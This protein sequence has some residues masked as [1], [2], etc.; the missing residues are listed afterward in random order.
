MSKARVM[1]QAFERTLFDCFAEIAAKY[2][3]K[4]ALVFNDEHI[5][6]ALLL[7]R[8]NIKA[9]ALQA[10]WG[11]ASGARVHYVGLND[12]EQ[13]VTLLACA[14][15][16][17][18]FLPINYRLAD[19]EIAQIKNDA[20]SK[21]DPSVA[22]RHLPYSIG[23]THTKQNAEDAD[24][25]LPL[26]SRGN[27]HAS[28]QRGLSPHEQACLLVYT[29]GTT[30]EHKG[31]LHT[32]AALLAN[33]R[34][35]WAAH[36]MTAN[37]VVLS[38][39]PLFH[40]GGLCIQTLPAL[41]LGATVLLHERFDAGAWLDAVQT[42]RPTLSL[43]V[44]ATMKAIQSESSWSST[45]LS[46]L[47]GVMAG[48][49]TIPR[50]LIDAFHARG[51]PVGQIYGTTETGPVSAVLPFAKAISH[52][53]CAGWPHTNCTI[54]LHNKNE[55]G[56]GEVCIQANNL[57]MGYWNANNGGQIGLD[58]NNF[59]NTGDL[60]RFHSDG[61][62]EIVGRS[63]DM[64]ISGGE[65]I[66]PAEIENALLAHPAIDE[67]AVIGVLDNQWGEIPVAY[68]VLKNPPSDGL[69]AT[70][71]MALR[72]FLIERIAKFKLPKRF[73]FMKTLPKS[74]LGKVLKMALKIDGK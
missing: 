12:P 43:V 36:N 55:H 2:S 46:S 64:L 68:V 60:G 29:S 25:W 61:C 65:N 48:S 14:K 4:T 16:G 38:T 3:S 28:G 17:A 1:S 58:S 20:G 57:M 41:L 45:D 24:V 66:Y 42:H 26:R 6:Y 74:A 9:D 34:A 32:Q 33:A 62:L 63:K 10:T 35:A 56:I 70:L 22:A 7:E 71:D 69:Q 50:H 31:A 21:I 39:L 53:G 73:V 49:S 27:V 11:L 67:C 72:A 5:S 15:V 30:G 13:I 19:A 23:A 47:R 44:P 37:D 52:K 54:E 18:I 8:I 40:V 59:F 51:V